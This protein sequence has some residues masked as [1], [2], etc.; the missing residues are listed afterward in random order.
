MRYAAI[1][2][3][4]N[5]IRLFIADI[6]EFEGR[7]TFK[8]NTLVRVPI[9]LGDDVFL[10]GR[11]SEEKS[12]N[13][14]KAMAAFRQ[15]MDVYQVSDY[16]AYATS[17][18][19]ESENG[20]ALVNEIKQVGIDLQIV[21]GDQEAKVIYSNQFEKKSKDIEP[22]LY[23]DVGGGSTELS[24]FYKRKLKKSKSFKIGTI[25]LLEDSVHEKTWMEMKGWIEENVCKYKGV[26]GIGTGG[27]IAR[28]STLA[29]QKTFKPLTYSKL[30]SVHDHLRSYSLKERIVVLG[31]KPDRA[32]VIIP[33]TEI[34]LN[35]M[36]WGKVKQIL[37][38]QIGVVDGII[39]TL[40]DRNSKKNNSQ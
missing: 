28:I 6:H 17:A 30:K 16:L 11:V 27:N 14:V 13:L 4:S 18:M 32:D 35:I 20:P 2:I 39:Q 8:K 24:M 10:S 34:F 31:L 19:R 26:V 33:A 29:N 3:G 21:D 7:T 23:I 40:I 1:D 12:K 36:K 22:F 9:R 5:A 37:V 15:L 38:P 25:R